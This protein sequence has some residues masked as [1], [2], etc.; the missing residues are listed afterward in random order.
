MDIRGEK[1]VLSPI[2]THDLEFLCRIECDERLWYFEE[3]VE[4][5]ESIV[6]EK[7]AQNIEQREEGSRFDFIVKVT[8]DPTNTLIGLAQIWS[9][10]EHRKSWEIGFAI[11]PEYAGR[12]YGT[13]AAKLLLLFAF[14]KLNAH[15]VVAM[16]NSRNV[17]SAQLLERIGM[18]REAVF[19]EE[20]FW[21]ND[22]TDQYFYSMLEKEFFGT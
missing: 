16:C 14:E 15:K 7:Y 18:T 19:K 22:W 3:F 21:Q 17:R 9:Y 8:G 11:L 13:E 1:V 4:S 12:G 10:V 20:L 5:D 2:S 6:R